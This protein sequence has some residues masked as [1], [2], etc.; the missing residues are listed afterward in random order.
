MQRVVGRLAWALQH[1][2][3]PRPAWGCMK[4]RLLEVLSAVL[5]ALCGLLLI[6]VTIILLCCEPVMILIRP[7]Y[8]AIFN[9][10]AVEK[11]MAQLNREDA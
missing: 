4:Q 2:L 11:L 5:T 1:D 8:H 10:A 3:R 7:V 9:G 6:S